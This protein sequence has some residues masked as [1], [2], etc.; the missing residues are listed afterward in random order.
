MMMP[1]CVST[2]RNP[3]ENEPGP[4]F[5]RDFVFDVKPCVRPFYRGILLGL[6]PGE[7]SFHRAHPKCKAGSCG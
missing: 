7:K 6:L 5:Y 3:L 2:F 4:S 1:C